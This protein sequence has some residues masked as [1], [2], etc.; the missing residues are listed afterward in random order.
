MDSKKIVFLTIDA[1]GTFLKSAILNQDGEVLEGSGFVTRSY[2]EGSREK[3]LGAIRKTILYGINY[4]KRKGEKPE[5]IGMAF[6]GPFDYPNASPLMHHKFK[7]IYGINL[8][9]E[10]YGIPAISRDIP[11]HFVHDSTA[12]LAGEIW[13]GNAQGFEN[14]AVITIGTGLGFTFSQKGIIQLNS[15]GGPLISLYR[16]P[17]KSGILEDFVSKRGLLRIFCEISDKEIAPNMKVSDIG[18]WAKEGE[19][20]SIRTFK[21]VGRILGESI[22]DTVREKNIQCL[23]FGGQISRSFSFMESSL[24]REFQG[25]DCLQKVAL[26]K[27]I[28]NAA[29]V[30]ILNTLVRDLKLPAV[31]GC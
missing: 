23:L 4:L 31:A 2:S 3:I 14:V 30:G 27:S 6:P 5:G 25:V 19:A 8:R 20:N 1:G 15:L 9:E 11:L 26:V 21:E 22:R 12:V 17:Y 16:Y 28:D 24:I 7:N 18:K 10:I 29:L 13:K